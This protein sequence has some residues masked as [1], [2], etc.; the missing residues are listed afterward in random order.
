MRVADMNGHFIRTA[1]R[2]RVQIFNSYLQLI[3]TQAVFP[4]AVGT[5][6]PHIIY[7]RTANIAARQLEVVKIVGVKV[8]GNDNVISAKAMIS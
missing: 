5:L 7:V 8:I 4:I 3:L 2:A 6:K 1:R